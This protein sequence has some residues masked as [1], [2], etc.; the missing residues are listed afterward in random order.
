MSTPADPALVSELTA[1]AAISYCN[2]SVAVLFL[3]YYLTTLQ[4]EYKHYSKHKVTLAT[5]L[6]IVNR[7][8]P[9]VFAF[10]DG[11]WSTYSSNL[12]TCAA[13]TG[14]TFG[15][16]SLQY[17]PWAIFSALRTYALQRKV[18]WAV[19]VLVLSLAPVIVNLLV[20]P[21]LARAPLIIAD[22]IIIV[23]TWK[24]QYKTY[25]LSKAVSQP[26]RLTNVIL[27][28]GTIY[29]VVLTGL[30]TLLL[31]FEYLQ[32]IKILASFQ[33]QA[34]VS[35]LVQFVEPVTTILISEFL[36][37]L[38]E[39]AEAVE[40]TGTLPSVGT[41]EFR[42]MGPIGASLPGLDDVV[43]TIET[44]ERGSCE[45]LEGDQDD[46]VVS[47]GAEVEEVTRSEADA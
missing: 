27:R 33:A 24:T 41:L 10:Y 8:F 42:I 9:L 36:T 12:R 18:Y 6:Y 2:T 28:D 35:I 43:E 38:Y 3:Y 17:F 4:D 14:L 37:H 7:Y 29:F 5:L 25:K 15:L 46:E 20:V 30:N 26:S 22:V 21:V 31:L 44:E 19:I 1:A 23:V 45:A 13:Q 39:A 40:D 32:Y 16:E 11:P 34:D 47:S